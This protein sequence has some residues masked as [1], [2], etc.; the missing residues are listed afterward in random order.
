MSPLA[1]LACKCRPGKLCLEDTGIPINCPKGYYCPTP[2]E[3]KKCPEGAF[4]PINTVV[5]IRCS[6]TQACPEGTACHGTGLLPCAFYNPDPALGNPNLR[7]G[8]VRPGIRTLPHFRL[9]ST[10]EPTQQIKVMFDGL[11][12]RVQHPDAP[13]CRA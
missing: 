4:C 9:S 11:T 1:D 3:L 10:A 7:M 8:A 13:P 12:S 6:W 2:I 5:P